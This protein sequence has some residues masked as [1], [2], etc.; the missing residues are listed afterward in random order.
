MRIELGQLLEC[1]ELYGVFSNKSEIEHMLRGIIAATSL[2]ILWKNLHSV[3]FMI[4][5]T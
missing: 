1:V 3:D 5:Q 2:N 4:N